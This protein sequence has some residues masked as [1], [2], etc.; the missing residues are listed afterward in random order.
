PVR[1]VLGRGQKV[2]ALE[3]H[4]I[5][6]RDVDEL[7]EVDR[8]R[9]LRRERLEL[10]VRHDDELAFVELI[11]ADDLISR[12]ETLVLRAHVPASQRPQRLIDE[13]ERQS[14]RAHGRKKIDGQA[15]E[16]ERDRARPQRPRGPAVEL[17]EIVAVFAF[18]R[19][20]RISL[21][22]RRLAPRRSKNVP[23]LTPA[24]APLRGSLATPSRDRARC[25][26]G[27]AAHAA[28][29]SPPPSR[30]RA[31]ARA[32]GTRPCI[33]PVRTAPR[34]STTVAAPS[35]SRARRAACPAELRARTRR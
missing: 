35:R 14:L 5:D 22:C 16:A 15:Q 10:L 27:G 28:P 20:D 31:R 7:P 32:C 8:A 34:G 6:F 30:A 12:K 17:I 18:V 23:R 1:L 24:C 2:R 11:A 21:A 29:S 3:V 4:R 9:L 19:H 33:A 26:D 13:L 25:G